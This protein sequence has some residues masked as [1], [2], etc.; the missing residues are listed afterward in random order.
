MKFH[1]DESNQFPQFWFQWLGWILFIG[2][3]FWEKW[4]TKHVLTPWIAVPIFTAEGLLLESHHW[5]LN[6]LV[7]GHRLGGAK[8]PPSP[9]TKKHRFIYVS[10]FRDASKPCK[11]HKWHFSFW[12]WDNFLCLRFGMVYRYINI[13]THVDSVLCQNYLNMLYINYYQCSLM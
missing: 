6:F 2:H 13:Y 4:V 8:P 5:H 11:I 12:F 3:P 10:R 9:A 7:G 1:P